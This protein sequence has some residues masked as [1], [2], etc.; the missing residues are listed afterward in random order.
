[1]Q[2]ASL[3]ALGFWARACLLF[4]GAYRVA[5]AEVVF[6]ENFNG[7]A[8]GE[9]PSSIVEVR[10]TPW[11]RGEVVGKRYAINAG[12][13]A[14]RLVM[15]QV[16]DFELTFVAEPHPRARYAPILIISLREG[17]G[18]GYRLYHWFGPSWSRVD[19]HHW[20][21]G[22][23]P[24]IRT[25]LESTGAPKI[26]LP[27]PRPIRWRLSA[28]G[29]TFALQRN[30]EKIWEY[31]DTDRPTLGPGAVS[32]DIS[33]A[34]KN[35]TAPI[36]FD[37]M[38]VESDDRAVALKFQRVYDHNFLVPGNFVAA[39]VQIHHRVQID[40]VL[41]TGLDQLWTDVPQ[42]RMYRV[43]AS[44][45]F[46]DMSEGK[47]RKMAAQTPY[48]RLENLDGSPVV[49]QNVFT[50]IL[51]STWPG[52]HSASA[53]ILRLLTECESLPPDGMLIRNA[54][55]ADATGPQQAVAYLP[56]LPGDFNVTAGWEYWLDNDHIHVAGPVEATWTKHGK[57]LYAGRPVRPGRV[58][59]DLRSAP[60]Q[61]V[62]RRI[63][64]DNRYY[65]DCAAFQECN[66]YFLDGEPVTFT[67][68]CAAG[69]DARL[70]RRAQW[71]LMDCYRRRTDQHGAVE[72]AAPKSSLWPRADR[73]MTWKT[74][75][76][77]LALKR[78]GVYW[79]DLT[80][81][82]TTKHYA[83]S[84]V[85]ADP[86]PG[87]TAAAS[88]G[89]PR[90]DGNFY[91]MQRW[92]KDIHH[93]VSGAGGSRNGDWYE[94][95]HAYNMLAIETGTQPP[96]VLRKVDG[97]WNPG[98][99]GAKLPPCPRFPDKRLWRQVA[100]NPESIKAFLASRYYHERPEDSVLRDPKADRAERWQ[101]LTRHHLKEWADYW[102][103]LWAARD[104]A[105]R[106]AIDAVKPGLV[107]SSYGPR[108]IS[109]YQYGNLYCGKY[110]G[111]DWKRRV[112]RAHL[113]NTWQVETY[114]REFGRPSMTY[115]PSLALTKMSL[116]E[117]DCKWELYGSVGGVEDSRLAF[118][119]PPHGLSVPSRDGV[120]NHTVEM[121]LAPWY[122]DGQFRPASGSHLAP[123]VG[124]FT[125]QQLF[126]LIDGMRIFHESEAVRPVR[127]P[128]FVRSYEAAELDPSWREQSINNSAAEAPAY[129]YVQAR[130][131]GLA[132][133]F[134][135]DI[136]HVADLDADSAD[137]LVLP[138]MRGAT[139]EQIA[140]IR[141]KYREGVALVCFDDCTGLEDLFGVKRLPAG[142]A[143]AGVSLGSEKR[144]VADIPEFARRERVRHT[145]TLM[146]ELDTAHEILVGTDADGRRVAPLLTIR[147]LEGKPG[148]VFYA[149]GAT[150]VGR[151]EKPLDDTNHEGE[152]TSN[153]IRSC[154]RAALRAIARPVVTVTS[155]ASVL[156]FERRDGS[157]YVVVLESSFPEP[158]PGGTAADGLLSIHCDAPSAVGFT[159]DRPLLRMP[160]QPGKRTVKL[161]LR[162]DGVVAMVVRI[163]GGE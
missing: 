4:V 88:S 126:G 40:K 43:T 92:P 78:P 136:A 154:L 106:K 63:R 122:F 76:F 130:M 132:G 135:A 105:L 163:H 114:A 6:Q 144:V 55:V 128:A 3:P 62:L 160:P 125:Q 157:L 47:G 110:Y 150:R 115:T 71:Q 158:R 156:A 33:L 34:T 142:R 45:D 8:D 84:I 27:Q 42:G 26:A 24:P 149:L 20:D 9:R 138:S 64:K 12:G 81:G 97:V 36:Y 37:D 66:H 101:V 15:P 91:P 75:P 49:E 28:R 159:C 48:V 56:D 87:Y 153:L 73:K 93:Y 13:N 119:R 80:L 17:P 7:L 127:S 146:Y 111:W 103:E 137:M 30:G 18:R 120:A 94:A 109:S 90:M 23:D 67:V 58:T 54:A 134:F 79:I 123:W 19:F 95:V 5:A 162:P 61:G 129:A 74:K 38:R 151:R 11:A 152:V 118:G 113:I 96:E 51:G 41:D 69:I 21:A 39:H 143:I 117:V 70:D 59:F 31:T 52:H 121:S 107:T 82:S 147:Q 77:V 10:K 139:K 98:L 65:A 148:A 155:P 35:P 102:S 161:R 140:A 112:G 100:A 116:P 2:S 1:M 32:L 86:R 133:G 99:E 53:Q 14:H 141:K 22:A 89:L 44:V 83:F 29:A 60:S 25:R 108:L 16:R 104:A 50:G 57:L 124:H 46:P 72:L 131:A 68:A 85:P 145:D